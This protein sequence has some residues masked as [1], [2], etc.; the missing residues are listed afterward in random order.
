MTILLPRTPDFEVSLMNNKEITVSARFFLFSAN[1]EILWSQSV[2]E[3]KI[4]IHLILA[5]VLSCLRTFQIFIVPICTDIL[6]L[7]LKKSVAPGKTL[8]EERMAIFFPLSVQTYSRFTVLNNV[9]FC[10]APRMANLLNT[11]ICFESSV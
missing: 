3:N 2:P 9:S 7:F 6:F 10:H 1:S 4:W 11:R 8:N 5:K